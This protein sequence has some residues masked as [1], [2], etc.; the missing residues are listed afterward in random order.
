M[1]RIAILSAVALAACQ[2]AAEKPAEAPPA[3]AAPGM[4]EIAFIANA[5]GANVSLLDVT[6]QKIIATIDTNP[7]KR[8]V[9]RPGTPNY[10]Q[11]TDVSPDGATLYVSRGYMGDVAAFDIA[12][13][14]QLWVRNLNTVRADHMTLT[15]DGRYLFVS[16]LMDARVARVDAK[17]GE[18]TG[19]FVSGIYPHDNQISTDGRHVYNTSLGNLQ[20]PPAQRDSVKAPSEKSGYAYEFTTADIETLEVTNRIRMPAGI[21]PWHMKPDGTGFYAQLSDLHGVVAIDFPSGKETKRLELPKKDGVTE[22]DWDFFSPH[23][24]LALSHDG[25]TLCLAGRASDYAALVKA[26]ELELIATIPVADAPGWAALADNDRIC[27]IASTRADYVS[28]ISVAEKREVARIPAGDGPKH[29]TVT[30]IPESIIA[31]AAGANSGAP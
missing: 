4:R 5:E 16:V 7:E 6:A 1:R 24:G 18:E 19:R 27:V 21:R 25:G 8:K 12:T 26:P 29:I 3:P 15:P 22:A 30:S 28:L 9:D 23:H 31:S 14:K 13:G 17:T 11:D 10:A 2:P 20:L